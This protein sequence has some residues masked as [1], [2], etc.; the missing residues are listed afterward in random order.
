MTIKKISFLLLLCLIFILS[1]SA[2]AGKLYRWVDENGK[3]SF[4]DKVPPE[5]S[6]KEHSQL[7]ESGRTIETK[8]AAKTPEQIALLKDIDA[9]QEIQQKLLSEQLSRDDALLKTFQSS[10]DIDTL[11]KSKSEMVR[12]HISIASSQSDTLRK[13]LLL[14]QKVAASF[15][16]KGKKVPQKKLD[17]IKLSQEQFDKNQREIAGFEAQ[18]VQIS[19]QLIKDKARFK[20]LSSQST[21]TPSIHQETVPSLVLGKLA[22]SQ[23]NCEAL[24]EKAQIFIKEQ[25]QTIIYTS[26]NLVL[27]KTPKR[28]KDRGLSLTLL[29]KNEPRQIML[30]I[31]CADSAAGKATCKSKKNQQLI[32]TFLELTP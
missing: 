19:E 24:W 6:R 18:K 31:R 15:E 9:L 11:A 10:T 32:N 28:G 7:N 26:D 5:H 1:T 27:T 14:H 3:V 16:L 23:E 17:N 25:G 8:D 12:S 2:T 20:T 29:T 22:C 30:D 13:Q 4:S 21:K